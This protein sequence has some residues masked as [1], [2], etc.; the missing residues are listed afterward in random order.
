MSTTQDTQNVQK[1]LTI[2]QKC[3]NRTTIQV[4][5]N[6]LILSDINFEKMLKTFYMFIIWN[7]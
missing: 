7:K 4:L 5:L 2:H 3:G 1:L 6:E